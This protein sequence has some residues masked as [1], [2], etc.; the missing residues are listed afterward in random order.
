MTRTIRLTSLVSLLDASRTSRQFRTYPTLIGVD[1]ERGGGTAKAV[2]IGIN[3][4]ESRQMLRIFVVIIPFIV[5]GS[6][7][8]IYASQLRSQVLGVVSLIAIGLGFMLE[9]YILLTGKYLDLARTIPSVLTQAIAVIEAHP[10]N[11]KDLTSRGRINK[12][13]ERVARSYARLPY[14]L[15]GGDPHT[16]TLLGDWGLE[17]AASVRDLKQWVAHPSAFT[18]TDLLHRLSV[19]LNSALDGRWSEI[20]RTKPSEDSK[21]GSPRQRAAW[22]AL[23]ATLLALTIAILVA[24]SSKLGVG[25]PFVVSLFGALGLMAITRGGISLDGLTKAKGALDILSK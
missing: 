23:G 3:R 20:P 11:W 15:R 5:T 13:L 22:L 9:F 16:L 7:A 19:D 6:A 14:Q 2:I 18:Y 17:M 25:G 8:I 12:E 10:E 24:Y 21:A 1:L 4:A